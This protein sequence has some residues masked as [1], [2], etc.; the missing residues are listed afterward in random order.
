MKQD[1]I[2]EMARQAGGF[3]VDEDDPQCSIGKIAFDLEEIE[4]FYKLAVEK[5]RKDA[6]EAV[7]A[8]I[9]PGDI[10]GN[11][12]DPSAQRGGIVLATNVL[13]DRIERGQA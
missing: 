10:G 13:M 1:E 6:W 5:E 7:N 2:I 4:A 3:E 9:V 8:L 12:T 11:G